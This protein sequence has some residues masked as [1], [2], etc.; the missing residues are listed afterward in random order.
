MRNLFARLEKLE[1]RTNICGKDG[2]LALIKL[3]KYDSLEEAVR[4]LNANQN[5]NFTIAEVKKWNKEILGGEE[6][7]MHKD[8]HLT[9]AVLERKKR[10]NKEKDNLREKL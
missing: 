6:Y 7:L 5:L 3:S 4:A 1:T 8:F 9:Y 2:R 10:L